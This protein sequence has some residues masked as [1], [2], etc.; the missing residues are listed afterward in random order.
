MRH[1]AAEA[2]EIFTGTRY[3]MRAQELSSEVFRQQLFDAIERHIDGPKGPR[4]I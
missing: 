4:Y 1:E 3:S 2:W